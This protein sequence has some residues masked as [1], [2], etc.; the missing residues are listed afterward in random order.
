MELRGTIKVILDAVKVNDKLTKQ[1]MVLTID[2]DTKYPQNIAIEFLNEKLDLVK[3][4]SIG[5]K[6][7][8]AVNLRGNEYNGKYYNNIVGWRVT[9]IVNNEVTNT[10]QNPARQ[11]VDLPF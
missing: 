4:Q 8:V 3:K 5:N 10:Q 2:E 7:A 9:N 11:E 6:V 1:Q